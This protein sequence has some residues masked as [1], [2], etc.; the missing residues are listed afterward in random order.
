MYLPYGANGFYE[1]EKFCLRAD[2][3]RNPTNFTNSVVLICCK[4]RPPQGYKASRS[5]KFHCCAAFKASTSLS[6]S[7]DV[8]VKFSSHNLWST[9]FG[10]HIS[11]A[12]IYWPIIKSS[13]PLG[14]CENSP[15]ATVFNPLDFPPKNSPRSS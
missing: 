9:L 14:I 12:V 13:F 15:F 4:A 2:A 5:I 11:L 1:T 3:L 10:H 6:R 8:E 7:P